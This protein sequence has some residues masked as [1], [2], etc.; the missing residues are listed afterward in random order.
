MK[1]LDIVGNDFNKKTK[2]VF[3][4]VFGGKGVLSK[5]DDDEED[6]EEVTRLFEEMKLWCYLNAKYVL[7]KYWSEILHIK[8]CIAFSQ[9]LIPFFPQIILLS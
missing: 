7:S 3:E 4:E 2:K 8:D 6:E 1:R 5:F 9:D